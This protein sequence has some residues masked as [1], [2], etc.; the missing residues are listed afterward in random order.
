[1]KAVITNKRHGKRRNQDRA[2]IYVKSNADAIASKFYDDNKIYSLPFKSNAWKAV[3]RASTALTA[4]AIEYG[5]G[6]LDRGRKP[7]FSN[8]AGCSCGCS[9]GYIVRNLYGH[10]L[11]GYNVWMDIEVDC[12]SLIAKIPKF[13]KKLDAEIEKYAA[14]I[15]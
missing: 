9:P 14:S 8:T 15:A 7:K 4:P 1:M 5:G 12:S 3:M 2:I 13:Q 6:F 11:S 10:V